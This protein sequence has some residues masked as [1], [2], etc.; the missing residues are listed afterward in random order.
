VQITCSVKVSKGGQKLRTSSQ[1]VEGGVTPTVIPLWGIHGIGHRGN[2]EARSR[3]AYRVF[4]F[5]PRMDSSESEPRSPWNYAH[6]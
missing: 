1:F 4:V 3:K 2:E 5:W 6:H